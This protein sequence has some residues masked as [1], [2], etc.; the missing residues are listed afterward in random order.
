MSESRRPPRP[1]GSGGGR[2]G[3]P[4]GAK[5]SRSG[6]GQRGSHGRWDRPRTTDASP[7]PPRTRSGRGTA[8]RAGGPPPPGGPRGPLLEEVPASAAKG[9]QEAGP[10]AFEADHGR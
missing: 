6:G 2:T 7:P 4:G 8:E 1:S 3:S 9:Q 5:Q 10:A